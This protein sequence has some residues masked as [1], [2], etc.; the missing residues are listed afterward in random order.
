MNRML[1]A[2]QEPQVSCVLY[3]QYLPPPYKDT[4]FR[5]LE[6]CHVNLFYESFLLNVNSRENN[7]LKSVCVNILIFP[8]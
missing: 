1:D 3:I 8:R 7:W 2:G 5:G 6:K 4:G